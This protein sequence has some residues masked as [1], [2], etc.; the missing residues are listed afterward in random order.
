M[1][2]VQEWVQA[3]NGAFSDGTG[4]EH[5]SGRPR[6]GHQRQSTQSVEEATR[7]ARFAGISGQGHT[8]EDEP[9][10]LRREV[11][12]RRR[13]HKI[14]KKPRV[15]SRNTSPQVPVHPRPSV[16]IRCWNFAPRFGCVCQWVLRL[17]GRLQSAPRT[18]DAMRS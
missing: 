9:A 3:P 8:Q 13:E 17:E 14:L 5:C 6:L 7:N 12:E 18:N 11:E 2:T 4:A 15:S 10:R 16:A 1:Q